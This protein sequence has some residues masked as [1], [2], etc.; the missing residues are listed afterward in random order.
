MRQQVQVNQKL[1]D[2][3]WH[4]KVQVEVPGRPND[5]ITFRQRVRGDRDHVGGLIQKIV[6]SL[7]K[8]D[9][10]EKNG[11]QLKIDW[12]E[13]ELWWPVQRKWLLK[14][15]WMLDK[16]SIQADTELLF[17][18]RNKILNIELP[19]NQCL[20]MLVNFSSDV[21]SVVRDICYIC[22][23]RHHT[24]LSLVKTSN[25]HNNA[26]AEL[27]AGISQ[28]VNP[29]LTS[30]AINSNVPYCTLRNPRQGGNQLNNDVLSSGTKLI[31]TNN[32][33]YRKLTFPAEK[34]DPDELNAPKN[35]K[36]RVSQTCRFLDSLKSLME[37]GVKENELIKLRFKYFNFQA[38]SEKNDFIRIHQLYEQ[39]KFS[40]LSD[41]FNITE[42]QALTLASLQYFIDECNRKEIYDTNSSQSETFDHPDGPDT[43]FDIDNMLDSLENELEGKP[44]NQ[45]DLVN[46]PELS[47]LV[48]VHLPNKLL[49]IGKF[50]DKKWLIYKDTF[51]D[52][53][54]Q[55]EDAASSANSKRIFRIEIK[56][57][58]LTKETSIKDGIYI[59][60]IKPHESEEIWLK[61]EQ[62]NQFCKWYAALKLGCK[63]TTMAS[64]NYKLEID[65]LKQV[66]KIQ[67]LSTEKIQDQS[68]LQV[69]QSKFYVP[70]KYFKKLGHPKIAAHILTQQRKIGETVRHQPTVA[71]LNYINLWEHIEESGRAY[72]Q[73][74]FKKEAPKRE[75]FVALSSEKIMRLE[76]SGKIIQSWWLQTLREWKI[77]WAAEP[78]RVELYLNKGSQDSEKIEFFIP[79]QKNSIDRNKDL[80]VIHEYIGGY[81]F[82]HMSKVL[83][84]DRAEE[85]TLRG[86]LDVTDPWHNK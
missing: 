47:E 18:N 24:E 10:D 33:E 2:G 59:I 49:Q 58:E 50:Q 76:P 26:R 25:I 23:I 85:A 29:I 16:Y 38:L 70:R 11:R 73:V 21:L 75:E 43:S 61:F 68:Q 57:A 39:L 3:T 42:D 14:H 6:E 51:L 46:I 60:K 77:N 41:E 67:D 32:I 28:M 79:S 64:N 81:M 15:H 86:I 9:K 71:K 31:D 12:S 84:P 72:F 30:G 22:E 37:Q 19:N 35:M 1:A 80:Q 62:E 54:K 20:K 65:R 55:R 52:G 63:G 40:V 53:Y 13:Y 66:I 34:V 7:L 74:S 78:K 27:T 36:D 5:P 45:Q 69:V 17:T 44:L 82:H 48:R 83:E 4:L 56:R 8:D